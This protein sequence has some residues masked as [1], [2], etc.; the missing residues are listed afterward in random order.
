VT[1]LRVLTAAWVTASAAALL[2]ALVSA[3]RPRPPWARRLPFLALV[4]LIVHAWVC[5]REAPFA[6]LFALPGYSATLGHAILAALP[7]RWPTAAPVF[8]RRTL[9]AAGLVVLLFSAQRIALFAARRE[10][11][12]AFVAVLRAE[13]RSFDFRS[14]GWTDAFD[15]LVAILAAE[16]PFTEWKGI[17]WAGLRAEIRPRIAQAAATHDRAVY[18]RGLRELARRLPDGHVDLEGDDGGQRRAEA[19]GD[20]GFVLAETDDGRVIVDAVTAGSGAASAGLRAG[21]EVVSWNGEPIRAAIEKVSPL[22]SESAAT[23]DG[24][25]RQQL[26]LLTRQPV[27]AR[28]ELALRAASGDA[29]SVALT[30]EDRPEVAAGENVFAAILFGCPVES[31]TLE[32]GVW[33]VRIRYELPT[34]RCPAPE[35]ELGRALAAAA[36]AGGPGVILDLRDNFG[37]EDALVARMAGF[38]VTRERLYER[39]A[40]LDRGAGRFRPVTQVA[41]TV[42]PTE[43]HYA[44]PL[45][46]LI[47]GDTLSS[48]EGLPMVLKGAPN[49]TIVGFE[50]THGSFAINQKEVALPEGL[51]FRFPQAQSVDEN[52]RIQVDSDATGRGGILP[53][54][55]VP[56]DAD[57]LAALRAGRDVLVE[58]ALGI[59]GARRPR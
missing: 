28:V 15:L 14:A 1:T 17:D 48:G 30:A 27:G 35:A 13:P 4:L 43:P 56:R 6:L 59:L 18:Y 29:R 53:D 5:L 36:A 8:L 32:G 49:V 23:S 45:V 25:R 58:R 44:G 55:R 38:F 24:R 34:L 47:G 9:A 31:R 21:N 11:V 46:L 12:S 54:V 20:F 57:T 40:L 26:R 7:A 41:L 52:G 3:H 19:G 16:Y 42:V 51:T 10:T 22:W 2:A 50:G 39:P 33:Y 37:G